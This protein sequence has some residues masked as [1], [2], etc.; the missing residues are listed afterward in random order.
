LKDE[1]FKRFT[2]FDNEFNKKGTFVEMN[3]AE[4]KNNYHNLDQ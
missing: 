4:K 3:N 2:I 1:Q